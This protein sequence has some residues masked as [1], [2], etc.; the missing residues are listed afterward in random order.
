MITRDSEGQ[1][2]FHYEQDDD[3]VASALKNIFAN[4]EVGR[5]FINNY[6][7]NATGETNYTKILN[8]SVAIA[9]GPMI[10]EGI[11]L[12]AITLLI[13]SGEIR[14]KQVAPVA[15]FD[16]PEI[17]SR[18][19]DK[20]GKLL[21]QA[22]ISWGEMSRFAETASMADINRRKATDPQ[23]A[24]FVRTNLQREMAQEVGDAV[25]PAGA[26]Q[27]KAR[28]SNELS[29]FAL[30]YNREPIANLRPKGGFVT[31][32]GEQLPWAAFQDLLSRAT[33]ANLV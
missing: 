14:P 27:N 2:R 25:T 5:D 30:A 15:T 21:S 10:T 8:A 24:S 29:Q 20:N 32:A 11:L 12:H 18:P 28:V 7:T 31:L 26:P 13:D 17:D 19:R 3:E 22:Q 6:N 23:F 9:G 16:E 1:I 33:A 4:T